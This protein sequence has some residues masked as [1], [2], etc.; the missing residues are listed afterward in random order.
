MK[1]FKRIKKKTNV[2]V[3]TQRSDV[4]R[5]L[6]SARIKGTRGGFGLVKGGQDHWARGARAAP[7]P[8]W[9]WKAG[10]TDVHFFYKYTIYKS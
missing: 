9:G 2:S 5:A 3:R 6:A 4:S 8:G 10:G 1:N 7:F